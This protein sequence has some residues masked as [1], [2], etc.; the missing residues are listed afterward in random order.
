MPHRKT[1][2]LVKDCREYEQKDSVQKVDCG[3]GYV[4]SIC[5][6]VHPWSKDADTDKEASLYH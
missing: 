2:R 5:F 1:Y 4:E 3:N 6:L